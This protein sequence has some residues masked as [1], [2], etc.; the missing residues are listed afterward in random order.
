MF[1]V[2]F[3]FADS[4]IFRT[5]RV[6]SLD[7]LA[8]LLYIEQ[9]ISLSRDWKKTL[10]RHDFTFG[11]YGTEPVVALNKVSGEIFVEEILSLID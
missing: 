7:A 8:D 2:H 4:T 1:T 9:E 11:Y 5:E 10:L 6:S 3:T